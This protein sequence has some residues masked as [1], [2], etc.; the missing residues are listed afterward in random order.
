MV[1]QPEDDLS[2]YYVYV[3]YG[4]RPNMTHFDHMDSVPNDNVVELEGYEE[5]NETVKEQLR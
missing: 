3:K 2:E 5:L 1:L 4:D